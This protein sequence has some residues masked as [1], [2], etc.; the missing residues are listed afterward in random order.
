[1]VGRGGLQR[2]ELDGTLAVELP[3]TIDSAHWGQGFATEAA[4]AALE[5]AR[6]LGLS[7]VV[8]LIMAGNAASRRVAEKIGLRP[9]GETQHAGLPHLVYKRSPGQYPID[10]LQ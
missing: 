9:D 3:W 1:M 4:S 5:W 7:E 6:S 2:T 8:A 10:C